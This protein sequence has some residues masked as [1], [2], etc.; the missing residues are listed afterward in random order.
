MFE[1]SFTPFSKQG[2]GVVNFDVLVFL[3]VAALVLLFRA[4]FMA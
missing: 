3:E 4:R 1:R 2:L